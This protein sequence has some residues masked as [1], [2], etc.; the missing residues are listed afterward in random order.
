MTMRPRRALECR[1][2]GLFPELEVVA[3]RSL[4]ATSR[5][6]SYPDVPPTDYRRRNTPRIPSPLLDGHKGPEAA[7][8]PRERTPPDL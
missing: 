1:R 8:T 5:L 2:T 7:D 3:V 4:E 6:F